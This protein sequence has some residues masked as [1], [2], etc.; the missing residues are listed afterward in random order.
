MIESTFQAY[1][2]DAKKSHSKL[3]NM[4]VVPLSILPDSNFYGGISPEPSKHIVMDFDDEQFD[5]VNG[6]HAHTVF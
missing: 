3:W 2:S 5:Y 6:L 4:P 1:D